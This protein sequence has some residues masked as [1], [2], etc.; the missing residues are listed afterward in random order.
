MS[1]DKREYYGFTGPMNLSHLPNNIVSLFRDSYNLPNGWQFSDTDPEPNESICWEGQVP[2]SLHPSLDT[3][4]SGVWTSEIINAGICA[5]REDI[6]SIT[7]V[8]YPNAGKMIRDAINKV[9]SLDEN[10]KILIGGSVSPWIESI[11]LANRF[12]NITT[13]DYEVRKVDDSR[14]KFVHANDVGDAKFDLIISFSSI[15][16]DG[17]GRYGDP[18][19]PYGPYNAVDEF[20]ESLNNNGCLLCGIPVLPE[21]K[22][23]HLSLI[24][25]NW[26]VIFS[27]NSAEKLFRKFK[28]LDVINQPDGWKSLWQ[29]QPIY[30]LQKQ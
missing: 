21:E 4:K 24:Q 29:H 11:C 28:I 19:N 12:N 25:R 3:L 9:P 13:S 26:H 14:I 6:N 18:I 10:A 5:V 17:L 15:E 30:I 27:R 22:K 20:Y 1:L 7:P 8:H 2:I 16:H 23:P